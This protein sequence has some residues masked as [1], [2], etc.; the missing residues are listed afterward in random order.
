MRRLDAIIRPLLYVALALLLAAIATGQ[1]AGAVEPAQMP[2]PIQGLDSGGP[3]QP[4]GLDYCVD[5]A[6]F[7]EAC[8]PSGPYEPMKNWAGHVY[9][10]CSGHTMTVYGE[11]FFAYNI[12]DQCLPP[13]PGVPCNIAG[14]RAFKRP[15]D[16]APSAQ[17]LWD[18]CFVLHQFV[19]GGYPCDRKVPPGGVQIY[20]AIT[21]AQLPDPAQRRTYAERYQCTNITPEPTSSPGPARTKTFTPRPGGPTPT[22]T[23][24]PRPSGCC[25][26]MPPNPC[27]PGLPLCHPP[28]KTRTPTRTLTAP[29]ATITAT[30]SPSPTLTSTRI[31]TAT[32]TRTLP[33]TITATNKPT[34]TPTGGGCGHGS[35]API[36]AL[37]VAAVGLLIWRNRR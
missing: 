36:N 23:K 20:H 9:Q 27:P 33:P 13:A 15:P 32:R 11:D 2:I 17:E 1:V 24:T 4:T 25:D 18:R 14:V 19:G 22:K 10:G 21:L 16:T 30:R 34:P 29:P 3:P 31:P 26:P 7:A 8:Q 28:T 6:Y 12:I 5:P 35:A 37:A